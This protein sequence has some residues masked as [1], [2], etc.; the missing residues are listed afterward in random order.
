MT[1]SARRVL[2]FAAALGAALAVSTGCAERSGD[3]ALVGLWQP[4]PESDSS[5]VR[6]T[7]ADD[8]TF[9]AVGWFIQYA[10]QRA[11]FTE[12]KSATNM[13]ATGRWHWDAESSRVLLSYDE[14]ADRRCQKPELPPLVVDPSS[15]ET[16]LLV[17][18]GGLD[19]KDW[20]I[21]L[22]KPVPVKAQEP[23][24]AHAQNQVEC[25]R[26][27]GRWEQACGRRAYRCVTHYRDAGKACTDAAQ[28]TGRCLVDLTETCTASG[29]CTAA[30][31]PE[32]DQP[33]VG[34]CEGDDTGCGSFIEIR[35]GR[36]EPRYDVD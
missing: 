31:L 14:P 13:W 23:S 1:N 32:V 25:F 33:F 21:R 28:C 15:G 18:P 12:P 24:A 35:K 26:E 19:R 17:Y 7:L 16:D 4:A 36:A 29:E 22:R 20:R 6:L 11:V 2:G 3:A 9:H 8:H 30:S 34:R 10:C 5:V 27:H